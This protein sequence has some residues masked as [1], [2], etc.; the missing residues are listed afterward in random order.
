MA[1]LAVFFCTCSIIASGLVNAER[2]FRVGDGFGWQ[3]PG[4]NSSAVYTQW[5][6]TNRFQV[7]DSLSFEYKNDSVVEVENGT[8]NHC[9]GGQRLQIEVM[10][11]HHHSPLTANPPAAQPAPSPEQSS[12][13]LSVSMTR[14]SSSALLIGTLIA[15]LWSLP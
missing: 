8:L 12:G 15:L 3:K 10:G 2:V 9:K 6:K 7:G 11:L 5:A 13:V 4:Q 14:G 1:S